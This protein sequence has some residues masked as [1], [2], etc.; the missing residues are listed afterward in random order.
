MWVWGKQDRV[1]QDISLDIAYVWT[2]LAGLLACWLV[3]FVWNCMPGRGKT[4]MLSPWL[5]VL[6]EMHYGEYLGLCVCAVDVCVVV[7]SVRIRHSK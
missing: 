2:L 6:N 1:G 5:F 7:F 3:A 4:L